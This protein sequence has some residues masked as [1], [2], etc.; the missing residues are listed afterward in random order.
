MVGVHSFVASALAVASLVSGVA[1]L[2]RDTPKDWDSS[3]EVCSLLNTVYI[4]LTRQ[5]KDYQVY[6]SRYHTLNCQQMHNTPFFDQ[7]CHPR[8]VRH[9]ENLS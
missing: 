4:W 6:Q 3:L 8:S 9:Q 1:I 2:K 5:L 7:C